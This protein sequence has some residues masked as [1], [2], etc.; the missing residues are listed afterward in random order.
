MMMLNAV[1]DEECLHKREKCSCKEKVCHLVW[2]VVQGFIGGVLGVRL[3]FKCVRGE[4][5]II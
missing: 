3:S 1:K 2:R 4:G 5:L